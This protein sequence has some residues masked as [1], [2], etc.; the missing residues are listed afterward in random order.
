MMNHYPG[1]TYRCQY[2]GADFGHDQWS[3]QDMAKYHGHGKCVSACHY[4]AEDVP[5]DR[6]VCVGWSG[7]APRALRNDEAQ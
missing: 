7:N 6:D 5:H 1:A 3:A 2:C 4:C